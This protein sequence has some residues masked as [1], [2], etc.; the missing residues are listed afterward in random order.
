M[1]AKTHCRVFCTLCVITHGVK[2]TLCTFVDNKKTVCTFAA[3]KPVECLLGGSV[4]T[5]ETLPNDFRK[6]ILSLYTVH[7]SQEKSLDQCTKPR[8]CTFFS[9]I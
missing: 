5:Y 4:Q 3:K 6:L 8:S 2:N 9:D 1:K 7:W